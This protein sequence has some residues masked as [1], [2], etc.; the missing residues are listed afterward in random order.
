MRTLGVLEPSAGNRPLH[1]DDPGTAWL[2]ERGTVDVF[3]VEYRDDRTASAF[4]HL[5][6][7]RQGRLLFG[8]AP[9][10][11]ATARPG[12]LV[13]GLP[14]A[15]LRQVPLAALLEHLPERQAVGILTAQ[16]DAWVCE[17]A[18]AVVR[19]IDPQPRA[20]SLLTP[21][22]K[23]AAAGVVSSERGVMWLP[24]R[25]VQ[26]AYLG[27]EES[28]PGP[29]GLMPV[30]PGVWVTLPKPAEIQG[31]PSRKIALPDLLFCHL[32]EFHRL[33]LDAEALNRMLLLAD[34]ANL[35]RDRVTWRRQD[36]AESRER[37][38]A[39][40]GQGQRH[41][42]APD[43]G[44]AL[45]A[46][47][48]IVGRHEGL[49]IRAS[50]YAEEAQEFDGILQASGLRARRVRLGA[51]DGWWRG[52][53]GALLAFRGDDQ[54]P[55][56]L[57]PGRTGRYRSL[58][59]VSGERRR[60]TAATARHFDDEAWMLYRPLP[61]DR[62]VGGRDLLRVASRKL[63]PDLAQVAVA[64]LAAGVVALL[65]A[66]AIGI[67]VD[68]L[69]PAGEVG[70]LVQMTGLL[71]LLAVLAGFLNMLRGTATMRIEGRAAAR[72]VAA[73]WDRLLRLCPNFFRRFTAGELAAR[74]MSFQV[75]RDQVSGMVS[76]ALLSVLFLL[77]TFALVFAYNAALGWASLALGVTA[78]GLTASL[79]LL[80][81]EH[82]R[83]RFG[84]MRRL[85]GH[86]Y[87]SACSRSSITGAGSA[88]CAG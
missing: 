53:S 59:P 39:V 68:T 5:T 78:L 42:Y 6:R 13:K 46:A 22:P 44:S 49:T 36:E 87:Q 31:R 55:L 35:Q 83:R 79:G 85:S 82:H 80:Q 24:G 3:V 14:G 43:D 29:S 26:A 66:A 20:D 70:P 48:R 52:D 50:R 23:V 61:G 17:F 25:E 58:D 54:R 51:E 37:L 69:V 32:P 9:D 16:I 72:V 21:G 12:L 77:P 7:A 45:L 28:G 18:E 65:P 41:G 67:L 57:L 27:T 71:L 73:L 34:E 10:A 40:V 15:E 56:V 64:G 1:L 86:L 33:A 4:K 88:P 8:A 81:I 75:M 63:G 19:D 76:G 84:A 30:S 74:T 2:V 11:N 62:P 38:Y 60:I 47:L